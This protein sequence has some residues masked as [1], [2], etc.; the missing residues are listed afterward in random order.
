MTGRRLAVKTTLSRGDYENGV[1]ASDKHFLTRTNRKNFRAREDLP[2][3]RA[4]DLC[5]SDELIA[6]SRAI[7]AHRIL[8]G[9]HRSRHARGGKS[10]STVDKR[11]KNAGVEKAR[12]LQEL[13]FAGD[14]EFRLTTLRAEELEASPVVEGGC[15]ANRTERGK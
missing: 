2:L 3:A 4:N 6:D 1:A 8:R 9:K 14:R 11:T 10:A 7:A 13:R 15:R 12:L 5:P